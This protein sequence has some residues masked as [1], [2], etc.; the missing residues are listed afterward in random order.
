MRRIWRLTPR[1]YY[2]RRIAHDL[3]DDYEE[4]ENRIV[5][6]AVEALTGR[7]RKRIECAQSRQRLFL[8]L[9]LLTQVVLQWSWGIVL[10]V[11]PVY[12]QTNCSGQT[13]LIFFLAPFT[14]D[15]I[16]NKLM[17]VWVLWLLFSLGITLFMT[18]VLALTSPSRAR[19]WTGV[20]S[21][22]ASSVA[23]RSSSTASATPR[24]VI[25][26]LFVSA[27]AAV[28]SWKDRSGQLIFWYNI[29]CIILWFVY[30]ICEWLLQASVGRCSERLRSLI[31][32][33]NGDPDPSQLSL[34]GREHHH[35]F[36]TG[37]SLLLTLSSAT[38]N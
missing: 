2:T 37:T 28:P 19:P 21:S 8:A 14:A 22:P 24:P 26:Q 15:E 27:R 30:I 12:S 25:E 31:R 4:H 10:F 9:A 38:R 13:K 35:R 36:R 5:G 23:T 1:E 3:L 18:V 16:N 29:G 33:S 11:S 17:V 34:R 20:R 32:S 7:H 6:S